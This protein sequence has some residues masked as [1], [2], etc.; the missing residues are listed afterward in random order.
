M[1]LRRI[2]AS[3]LPLLPWVVAQALNVRARDLLL[4]PEFRDLVLLNQCGRHDILRRCKGNL[5]ALVDSRE[6]VVGIILL[7]RG[8]AIIVAG[9]DISPASALLPRKMEETMLPSLLCLLQIFKKIKNAQPPKR[10]KLNHITAEEANE[11]DQVPVSM[12]SLNSINTRALFESSASHSFLSRK[13]AIEHQ[14]PIRQVSTPIILM[15]R[16]QT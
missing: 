4:H 3:G 2:T 9:M 1:H 13:F 5:P 7:P 16:V 8:R 10:G 6:V 11:D 12:V 14:F 15:P